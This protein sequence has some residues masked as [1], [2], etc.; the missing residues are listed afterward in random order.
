MGLQV[1]QS[2]EAFD[3]AGVENHVDRDG[4]VE[5]RVRSQESAFLER[6]G[7]INSFLMQQTLGNVLS[8]IFRSWH[9]FGR[10]L[11]GFYIPPALSG[12]GPVSIPSFSNPQEFEKAPFQLQQI[13][14]DWSSKKYISDQI[15]S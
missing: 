6:M 7:E 15:P 9:Y 2:I 3:K 14:F 12:W 8:P 10:A 11:L 4:E 13:A 1:G 5:I